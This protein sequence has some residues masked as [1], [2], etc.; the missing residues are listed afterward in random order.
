MRQNISQKV[1]Q[2]KENPDHFGPKKNN[3]IWLVQKAK[4]K[5]THTHTHAY[6]HQ[7]AQQ[8]KT[9]KKTAQNLVRTE[10]PTRNRNYLNWWYWY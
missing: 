6:Y 1:A 2:R 4:A 5:V 7:A 3:Q 10:L 8:T 9:R